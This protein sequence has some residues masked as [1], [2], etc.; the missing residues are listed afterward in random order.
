[1]MLSVCDIGA[2]RL[3]DLCNKTAALRAAA[4]VKVNNR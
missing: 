4:Q 3:C 1:M 2:L